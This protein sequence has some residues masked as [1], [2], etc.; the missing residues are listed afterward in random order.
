MNHNTYRFYSLKP[1]RAAEL[2]SSAKWIHFFMFDCV[3][4]V[5]TNIHNGLLQFLPKSQ[6]IKDTR[7]GITCILESDLFKITNA[8]M[9]DMDEDVFMEWKKG[10]RD[11]VCKRHEHGALIREYLDMMEDK[12]IVKLDELKRQ[13]QTQIESRLYEEGWSKKDMNP[14]PDNKIEWNKLIYQPKPITDRITS[15]FIRIVYLSAHLSYLVVWANLHPKLVGLLE[16]NCT[17]HGPAETE[18]RRRERIDK[19]H[20]LV[21]DIKEALPPLV[22]FELERSLDTINSDGYDKPS[23]SFRDCCSPRWD[24]LIDEIKQPFPTMAEFLTW[25]M[26]ERLVGEETLLEDVE[27]NFE[28][29]RDE[30]DQAVVEWRENVERDLVEI[31]NADRNEQGAEG[32][33]SSSKGKGKQVA[34]SEDRGRA[35][36]VNNC[37]A[38]PASRAIQLV[39]P[40]FVATYTK[41]D[42]T[43]TMDVSD[44]SANQQ[45]LLRADTIFR[46]T[47]LPRTYPGIVPS[48]LPHEYF[49]GRSS[50]FTYG[51]RWD[52]SSIKRDYEA[53]AIAKELLA[54]AGQSEASSVHIKA[55]GGQFKCG[56]CDRARVDTWEDLIRHYTIEQGRWRKAQEK[57]KAEP[58]SRFVFNSTHELEPGNTKPYAHLMTGNTA[59][60]YMEKHDIFKMVPVNPIDG[61]L[62]DVTQSVVAETR[63]ENDVQQSSDEDVPTKGPPAK[64]SKTTRAPNRGKKAKLSRLL[65]MAPEIFNEIA[66][67]LLPMD[68]LSLARSNKFFRNMF[69]SRTSQHLWQQTL[70]NADIPAC[71]PDLNEPQYV[72][73]IFSKTCST[74]GAG[75]L[76]Q[77][78]PYLHVRLC[79]S[80]RDNQIMRIS[81]SDQLLEFLPRSNKIKDTRRGFT[82]TLK[83]EFIEIEDIMAQDMDED[84][85]AEWQNARRAEVCERQEHGA[86]VQRYLIKAEAERDY[87]L[88]DLQWQHQKQINTRLL[89]EGWSRR[90][91]DPSPANREEWDKLTLLPKPLTDRIWKNLYPKLVPLLES[92]RTYNQR[93]DK[94]RGERIS[95][96]QVI[97]SKIREARPPLV[98]LTLK[99]SQVTESNKSGT[100]TSFISN[101]SNSSEDYPDVTVGQP[102][103]TM[104]ELRTWSMI[105]RLVMDDRPQSLGM[106]MR[107]EKIRDE[108]DLAVV[109]WRER[110]ERDLVEIWNADGGEEA[111][112][113]S[114]AIEGGA[115]QLVE[116][117]SRNPTSTDGSSKEP[118]SKLTLPEF[119]ATYT[120]PDGT[121]T[122]NISDLHPNFQ[123]LLRADTTFSKTDSQCYY[124]Y[125]YIVDVCLGFLRNEQWDPNI[126]ERDDEASAISRTLLARIGQSEASMAKMKAL[127]GIFRCGRC[128][129]KADN[130]ESLVEHYV[131]E[132]RRWKEAQ[133]ILESA[134]RY[135]FVFN[136]THG[137]EPANTKPLVYFVTP[138]EAEWDSM[139]SSILMRCLRCE[140]MCI[141]A[142]YS[143]VSNEEG[144]DSEIKEHVHNVHDVKKPRFDVHYR[145]C[146][147]SF[148]Y[149]DSAESDDEDEDEDNEED[150][151]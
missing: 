133:M 105:K 72:S 79:N 43:T 106:D 55:L 147:P 12:R 112:P 41:S 59:I 101:Q 146:D 69:M 122:T 68:L 47:R 76:R 124:T 56:R 141:D 36:L 148:R 78:D 8:A 132:Q 114:L 121:T 5:V 48:R 85:F 26:I 89:D 24:Q 90:D 104:A 95:Q 100:P 80:C 75:V 39:L 115:N 14:T 45:L 44:L 93:V 57:I 66:T 6:E 97:I 86:L 63:V 102:F 11:E 42:G 23:S 120:K 87:E 51:R 131:T 27:T 38:D 70:A 125:P 35:T 25:P 19:L 111:D 28:A 143:H 33:P 22:C 81:E 53:S 21:S 29:I 37:S 71:P 135:R 136:R 110:I 126:L 3:I 9:E 99:S 74:C 77:M 64:R 40:E 67:H 54:L 61:H 30:F 103:P 20:A 10:K 139:N 145:P 16:S 123:L 73:L 96:L 46:S 128:C 151:W 127:G 150:L 50:E 138:E 52:P 58:E 113:E 15:L 13:R 62:R 18:K 84:A 65:D 94:Q 31:W 117:N 130:W 34:T 109:E 91:T 129:V 60:D 107:F 144:F 7:D 140:N 137:F 1:A 82:Y 83:S 49:V 119:V 118:T 98:H 32:E 134:P 92:N 116:T 2:E 17:Y 149:F 142:S 88:W 108:F 4:R